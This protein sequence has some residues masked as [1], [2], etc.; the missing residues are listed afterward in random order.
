MSLKI[1][2]SRTEYVVAC[3]PHAVTVEETSKGKQQKKNECLL[4]VAG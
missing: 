3:F 2:A 1:V 4:H